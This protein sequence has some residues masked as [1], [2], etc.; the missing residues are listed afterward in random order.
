MSDTPP[1][2]AWDPAVYERFKDE[3]AQPFHDL[4]G[5]VAPL[6]ASGGA[7]VVDLGC[8]T[9]ELTRV[10]HETLGAKETLG[11]D[12]SPEML[13]RSE[14]LAGNGLRFRVADITTFQPD[15]PLDLVFS[16]AALHWLP[17]HRGLLARIT[18]WLAPGGQIAVQV[19]A[20]DGQPSHT[21]AAALASEE[22]FASA[23]SGFSKRRNVLEPEAYAALLH[24]LGYAEQHVRLQIYPHRLASPDAAVDWVKG[25]LLT[26]YQERLDAALY[27]LYMERYR[28]R[29]A[30]RLGPAR[31]VFFPYRRVL[32]RAGRAG[33]RH[34]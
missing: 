21:T 22:P 24:E 19:P 25:T 27:A 17:D 29:L 18:S 32:F 5:L 26:S 15:A 16:N 33:A 6:A 11:I 13:A 14:A 34:A 23:L 30:A 8:G 9:G 1:K 10:L 31:P 12:S 3:R 7:R 4:L 20:M 2:T 28:E